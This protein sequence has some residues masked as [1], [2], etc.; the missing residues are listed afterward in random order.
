MIVF[1]V[2]T[3]VLVGLC[4]RLEVGRRK[5]LVQITRDVLE[6]EGLSKLSCE[7]VNCN[8]R[9]SPLNGP[10]T[11]QPRDPLLTTSSLEVLRGLTYSLSHRAEEISEEVWSPPGETKDD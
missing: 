8:L 1:V 9:E 11:E 10:Y 2:L 6:A 7:V 5:S 3:M 4:W